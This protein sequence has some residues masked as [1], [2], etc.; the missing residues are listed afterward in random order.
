MRPLSSDTVTRLLGE[1]VRAL[2]PYEVL[3]EV[4]SVSKSQIAFPGASDFRPAMN[5]IA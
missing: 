5:S 2:E 4:F 3:E 1:V